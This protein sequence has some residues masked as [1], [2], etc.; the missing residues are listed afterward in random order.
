M[1]SVY[2]FQ[3][4]WFCGHRL[5]LSVVLLA[6]RLMAFLHQCLPL[7]KL[8]VKGKLMNFSTAFMYVWIPR[9]WTDC[10]VSIPS[11][12]FLCSVHNKTLL[13]HLW[14]Q[15]GTVNTVKGSFTIVRDFGDVCYHSY[16]SIM[17]EMRLQAPSE[18]KYY[19]IRFASPDGFLRTYIAKILCVGYSIIREMPHFPICSVAKIILKLL[20]I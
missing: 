15:D 2:W 17:K 19:E 8:L 12:F 14:L 10:I 16:F 18:G 5:A 1:Y 4:R 11:S 9:L 7:L 3:P 20:V 13:L 6:V